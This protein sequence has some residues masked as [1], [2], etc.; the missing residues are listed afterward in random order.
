MV[1]LIQGLFIPAYNI[2][3]GRDLHSGYSLSFHD[4][5]KE[6]EKLLTRLFTVSVA[7]G[8]FFT[9][10]A[11]LHRASPSHSLLGTS[12]LTA[13]CLALSMQ[14][15]SPF[16][17]NTGKITAG[18]FIIR[19]GVGSLVVSPLAPTIKAA[20]HWFA[21][22]SLSLNLL[23][24]CVAGVACGYLRCLGGLASLG[25][26]L[27]LIESASQKEPK[28]LYPIDRKVNDLSKKW[29]YNLAALF[30]YKEYSLSSPVPPVKP[31]QK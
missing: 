3:K 28:S 24:S 11:L 13:G 30:G 19:A 16:L 1:S 10:S 20:L 9:L 18:L 15:S 31:I 27:W 29:A 22:P 17:A 12:I 23:A 8:G 14:K 2:A 4:A 7:V 5:R 6:A 25:M 26:G 21:Q